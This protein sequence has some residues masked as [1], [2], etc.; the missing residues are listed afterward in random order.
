[1]CGASRTIKACTLKVLA[2]L[3]GIFDF[4]CCL[5]KNV[6]WLVCTILGDVTALVRDVLGSVLHE[7]CVVLEDVAVFVYCTLGGVNCL[8]SAIF[9]DVICLLKGILCPKH[10][11]CCPGTAKR[12]GLCFVFDL[13]NGL[14]MAFEPWLGYIKCGPGYGLL[15]V[16][17]KP[18]GVP[19]IYGNVCGPV[20]S[21]PAPPQPPACK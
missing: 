15:A 21:C 1:M 19:L 11:I 6:E 9:H 18:F 14:N 16:Q 7:L 3:H 5:L 4:T 12:M 13:L 2:L 17:V 10:D 8:V 20:P